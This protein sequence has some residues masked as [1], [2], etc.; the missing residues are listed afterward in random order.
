MMANRVF[1]YDPNRWMDQVEEFPDPRPEEIAHFWDGP[2]DEAEYA[3]ELAEHYIYQSLGAVLTDTHVMRANLQ[4]L[5]ADEEYKPY[6]CGNGHKLL[7][8]ANL[9]Y[10]FFCPLCGIYSVTGG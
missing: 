7:I 8:R 5:H 1:D 9:H 4:A 10:S 3:P 6:V 2:D